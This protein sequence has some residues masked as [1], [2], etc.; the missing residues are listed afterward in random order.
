MKKQIAAAMLTLLLTLTA[1][2]TAEPAPESGT[3]EPESAEYAAGEVTLPSPQASGDGDAAAE[4]VL[5]AL[6]GGTYTNQN[7]HL[8]CKLDESWLFYNETQLLE[9]NGVLTE[10]GSSDIAALAESG[11]AVYDMYAISTDGLMTMNV[12]YQNLGLLSGGSMTAQEYVELAAAKL[13]SDLSAG[14]FTDAQVQIS[15]TDIAA[16]K[17]CPTLL[18]TAMLQDTPMYERLVCLRAGNYIYCVTLCSFTKD[19]TA[20]MAALF[21]TVR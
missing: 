15:A 11:K 16:E 7:A 10:G 1:C 12:T 21:H 17:S 4:D 2:G 6:P 9:L 18:V 5:G 14:G 19:V 3:V 20:D 8:T 13:P